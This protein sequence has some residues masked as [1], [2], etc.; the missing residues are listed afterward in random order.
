MRRVDM[1]AG[2]LGKVLGIDL[3]E[4][5]DPAASRIEHLVIHRAADGHAVLS[6]LVRKILHRQASLQESYLDPQREWIFG[7][8][9]D[10][11]CAHAY[12]H[13]WPTWCSHNWTNKTFLQE[14]K[15][16]KAKFLTDFEDI[17][18]LNG[19]SVVEMCRQSGITRSLFYA[20][21][22]GVQEAS[23][24]TLEKLEKVRPVTVERASRSTMEQMISVNESS[25]SYLPR[26]ER[27]TKAEKRALL[28]D[29]RNRLE[30]LEADLLENQDDEEEDGF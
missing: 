10:C 1:V 7:G 20:I 25:A 19:W 2:R 11:L 9:V 22:D 27:L 23:A 18:V 4:C 26:R 16:R 13:P 6:Y 29:I 21:R 3:E 12:K 30:I 14:K 8:W 28:A 24:K 17:R 5:C 15:D